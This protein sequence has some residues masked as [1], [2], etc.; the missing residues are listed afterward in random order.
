MLLTIILPLV[1]A[2]AVLALPRPWRRIKEM[3]VLA[4]VSANLVIAFSLFGKNINLNLPWAGF[5]IDLSFRLYH[6]SGLILAAAA[7]LGFLVALYSSVFMRGKE[8]LSQ[9]YAYFLITLSFVS[10]AVLSDNLV[11]LLFFWEGILLTIFG[12]IAIGRKDAFKTAIKAFVIIGITDLCMMVGIALAGHI[13]GTFTISKINIALT[14]LGAAA[15][16]FLMIGAISKAGSMPFHS[17]IP[18]AAIDA[19]LPFMALLP[20]AIEKLLGI[21]FLT[22]ITLDMFK[23]TTGSRLSTMLMIIGA[24]TI[25]FAVMMAL[26]Q[27]DYKR[28]LSYHAISQVGYMI[29]GIGTALPVGIVGGIFHMINNAVYKS[30]LFLTGGSVESQAGTAD[31]SKLGGLGKKMPVTFGCFIIAALSIS[32]VPPFNGFFSKELVYDAALER[33]TIFYIV[34]ILGSF[35]TALSFLKLGHAAFLGKVS[36]ENQKVKEAPVA[37]LIPMVILSAVCVFFGLYNKFPITTLIQPILGSRGEGHSF[38]GFPANLTIVLVT[39]VVLI[40]AVLYHIIAAK[41]KGSALKAADYIHY[42]PVLF[43]IYEKAEARVFDPYEIGLKLTGMISRIAWYIDRG[44]DWVY[45]TLTVN[46]IY[47]FSFTLKS[48]HTGNYVMYVGWSLVGMAFVIFSLL[49]KQRF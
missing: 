49:F 12:L 44:I 22:R 31:L 27:K 38:A 13:S 36:Q 7:S 18:D 8:K 39:V 32:G 25:L 48:L 21:Y 41:K 4:A 23:L 6:F 3:I 2:I 14:P 46:V 15:F 24:I 1:C 11:L 20:A 34:A 42:A 37:M 19:P 30:C 45:E 9:F 17:W 28:L 29:L 10:G 43:G 33:H 35:F 5:G 40:G 16:V 47:M 26:V